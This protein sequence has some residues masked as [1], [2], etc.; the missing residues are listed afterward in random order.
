MAAG[1]AYGAVT[2]AFDGGLKGALVGAGNG[3]VGGLVMSINP[4]IAWAAFAATVAHT[5]IAQGI[6]G[7]SN[8]AQ[9][10]SADMLGSV[11]GLK[12]GMYAAPGIINTAKSAGQAIGNFA[13][14]AGKSI[15]NAFG[16]MPQKVSVGLSVELR[17]RAP[18]IE[19]GFPKGKTVTRYMGPEEAA[20]VIRTRNIPNYGADSLLRPTHVTTDIPLDSATVAAQRY[21]IKPP[22]HRV[23]VPIERANNL[24][25]APDG[26]PTTSGGGSQFATDNLIPANP[27]E[28][29]PLGS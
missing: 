6:P 18:S 12:I 23:T 10:A 4:A 29:Y 25:P 20:E 13:E 7:L 8:L 24:G 21:E 26:R 5:G 9:D 19:F 2:G 17:P 27:D 16:R 15:A 1:A 11:I 3:A 14:Q 22:T 28:I